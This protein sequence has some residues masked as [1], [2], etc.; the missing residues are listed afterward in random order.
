MKKLIPVFILAI[1]L[2]GC[3]HE[4]EEEHQNN[5]GN[6]YDILST[7]EEYIDPNDECRQK[8]TVVC[9]YPGDRCPFEGSNTET[10]YTCTFQTKGVESNSPVAVEILNKFIKENNFSGFFKNNIEWHK[11]LPSLKHNRRVV[12]FIKVSN[13]GAKITDKNRLIIFN[14]KDI[15]NFSSE[16]ILCIADINIAYKQS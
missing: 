10:F 8:I 2:I 12:N 15:D 16:N 6:V 14:N 11:I 9:G 4:E 1:A 5:T 13:L 3:S 7:H